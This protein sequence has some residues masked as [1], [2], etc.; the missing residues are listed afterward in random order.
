[1]CFLTLEVIFLA[2]PTKKSWFM[3]WKQVN[4]LSSCALRG[5]CREHARQPAVSS[6]LGFSTAGPLWLHHLRDHKRGLERGG[7]SQW[8]GYESQV[9]AALWLFLFFCYCLRCVFACIFMFVWFSGGWDTRCARA[10][11]HTKTVCVHLSSHLWALA[12]SFRADLR[13]L[14]KGSSGFP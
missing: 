2:A 7:P 5:R 13:V 12:L 9:H 1:M 14:V 6:R 10:A 8:L 11:F 3:L 4:S